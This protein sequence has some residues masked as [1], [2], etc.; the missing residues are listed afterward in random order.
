MADVRACIELGYS[1]VMIDGSKL[2]FESNVAL[3]SMV[4][5]EAA[6]RR[7]LG[8]SRT[9]RDRRRRGW[10]RRPS[11][12]ATA[13]PSTRREFVA[14][15][16]RRCP[17]RGVRFRPRHPHP[18][19]VLDL[20]L[21]ADIRAVVAVPLVM[22]GASGVESSQLLA[23]VSLGVAKVNYN[24]ELRRAYIG[25]LRGPPWKKETTTL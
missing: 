15:T 10:L 16:G 21:L 5:E 23:A 14:R 17:R 18:S 6:R 7:G 25:A 12:Q 11:R 1:S 24:A 19:I 3:S 2:D 4:V 20:A 13:R 8:G 22:H 9:W